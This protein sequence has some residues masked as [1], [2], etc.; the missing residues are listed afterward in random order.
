M[1]CPLCLCFLQDT[2]EVNLLSK[3]LSSEKLLPLTRMIASELHRLLTTIQGHHNMVQR[4][5][6]EYLNLVEKKIHIPAKP[7]EFHLFDVSLNYY[8]Y[9]GCNAVQKKELEQ[10]IQMICY[11]LLGSGVFKCPKGNDPLLAPKQWILQNYFMFLEQL[12]EIHDEHSGKK[13]VDLNT[14][15]FLKTERISDEEIDSWNDLYD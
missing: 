6:R 2:L 11:E 10:T 8:N 3:H 4:V 13:S 7:L 1:T 5:K 14:L 15:V 9:I 12:K